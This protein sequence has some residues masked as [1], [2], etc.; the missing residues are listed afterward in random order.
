[1]NRMG[2]I[3][4]PGD[5]DARTNHSTIPGFAAQV[6]PWNVSAAGWQQIM[7][8]IRD[9]FARFNV[10]ITDVDQLFSQVAATSGAGANA[11]RLAQLRQSSGDVTARQQLAELKAAAAAKKAA[12]KS[13]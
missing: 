4:R 8:C 1:M 13:M 2:G 11:A 9:Q 12:A 5:N 6:N 7:T 3:Y 10:T